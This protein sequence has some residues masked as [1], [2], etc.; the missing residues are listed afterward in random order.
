V[1][2]ETQR[3]GIDRLLV[4]PALKAGALTLHVSELGQGLASHDPHTHEG[5]EAFYILDGTA[6]IECE[7][8][9]SSVHK[10][11]GVIID[12]TTPHGIRNVGDGTL[13]YLVIMA[14]SA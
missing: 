2:E 14:G 8:T 1:F 4:H 9:L 5:I 3:K 12:A 10:D 7:G 13:R 6:G 11:E